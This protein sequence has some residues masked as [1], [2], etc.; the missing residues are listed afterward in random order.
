MRYDD[1]DW[2][3]LAQYREKWKAFV[4]TVTKIRVL[5]RK[6]GVSLQ[7]EFTKTRVQCFLTRA[8]L[9]GWRTVT[10]NSESLLTRGLYSNS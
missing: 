9:L 2:I 6:R 1:A 10:F 5:Y 8:N 3:H 4:R 7:T